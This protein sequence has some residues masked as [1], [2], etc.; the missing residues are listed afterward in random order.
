VETGEGDAFE[1]LSVILNELRRDRAQMAP[2]FLFVDPYGFKI[3]AA[4]LGDLMKAGRVEL[5][6]NVMWREL[7]MLIQQRP[8]PGTPH[9]QTL[10]EIFGSSSWR[11]EVIGDGMDERLDRAIPLMARGIGAKWWTSVRLAAPH[12][13]G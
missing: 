8:A 6:I 9:A 1:R 2:A 4:L 7:D 12:E 11:T 13:L 10:D 5:F 3:P